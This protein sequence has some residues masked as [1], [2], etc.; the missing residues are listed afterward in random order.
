MNS[1][2]EFTK[3]DNDI[4]PMFLCKDSGWQLSKELGLHKCSP[5]RDY[6]VRW[7][8]KDEKWS[9]YITYYDNPDFKHGLN[10]KDLII[11]V[12][13]MFDVFNYIY[14]NKTTHY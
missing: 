6:I 11:T 3:F 7:F 14:N 9:L 13:T 1:S 4:C 10:E 5:C 12:D 8:I 2:L